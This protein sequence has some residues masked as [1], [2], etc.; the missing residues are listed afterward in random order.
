MKRLNLS[1]PAEIFR[2]NSSKFT[3]ISYSEI[4]LKIFSGVLRKIANSL[5]CVFVKISELCIVN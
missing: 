1:V 5:L 2:H 4:S 3:L